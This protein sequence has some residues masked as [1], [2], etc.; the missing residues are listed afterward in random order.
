MGDTGFPRVVS[1]KPN[2]FASKP[3]SRRY[4]EGIRKREGSEGTVRKKTRTGT[5]S[6]RKNPLASLG[7]SN[8][9]GGVLRNSLAAL[10]GK[11]FVS[12]RNQERRNRGGR[13]KKET[14]PLLKEKGKKVG[15]KSRER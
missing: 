12:P 7:L 8:G 13:G 2:H 9:I 5:E 14:S 6:G 11:F 1:P 4:S 15:G 10:P 3:K